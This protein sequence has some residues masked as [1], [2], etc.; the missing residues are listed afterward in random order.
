[1]RRFA[2]TAAAVAVVTAASPRRATA[3]DSGEP[4]ATVEVVAGQPAATTLT[5]ITHEAVLKAAHLAAIPEDIA[6]QDTTAQDT[7][8][9]NAVE[10]ATRI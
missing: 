5:P 6:F 3:Q 8:R 9:P 7:G 10:Y 2:L 1:M 4:A